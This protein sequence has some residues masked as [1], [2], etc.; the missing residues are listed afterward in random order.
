MASLSR[1]TFLQKSGV[2]A[3]ALTIVPSY[4]VSGV[5]RKKKVKAPSDKLNIAGIGIGGMGHANL[6]QMA[7]ENIVA[8]CDAD[9]AYAKPIFNLYS[10]AKRYWDYRKMFDEMGK[11]IDAVLVATPDHLHAI[12]AAEAI[13]L[14]KHVYC[15]KPL[16]HSIYESRL[17]TKLAAKYKVCTQMGNQG[18]SG[19]GVNNICEWIW[20]G[21][22][23][24][25][26]RVDAATDRP[27]WPAG[28]NTP[29]NEEKVPDTFNWDL[30]TGPAKMRPYHGVYH[31]F[32]W[33]GW[34][35]YGTGSLGDMG[36]HILHPVFAALNL[37]Y[38]TMVEASSSS[39]LRD[40]TPSAEIIKYTFPAR[41]NLPKVAMPEVEVN[42]Y[43]GG[44]LPD[45][46][47]GFPEKKDLMLDGGG[48]TIF[49]GT[50]D[51]LVCA[52]YGESPFLLSGRVPSA[53][54]TLPRTKLSHEQDW[55]RACKE[56]PENRVL[57]KSDFSVAG[58][59]NEMIVMGAM[60]V[61]LQ[62]LH[63]T[64]LWDGENMKFTNIDD[65]DTLSFKITDSVN[66]AYGSVNMTE[67]VSAKAFAEE[68]VRHNYR[69]GWK[70]PEL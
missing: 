31:P 18:A 50:K 20:N 6:E 35:D 2:A 33:R 53:P 51:T 41:E 34:W 66:T 38:P 26:V 48:V 5:N 39:L 57:P 68:L 24:D 13:T 52:C 46:P 63:R 10:N 55:I 62:G 32:R 3:A 7:A 25:V 64:L 11:S 19:E 56:S 59:F 44:L 29:T 70:L 15:Q 60:A 4:A 43:D 47:K 12:I 1:R 67:P 58:P 61:R 40:C 54:K 16:T 23:G 36:C 27:W 28:I 37:R 21:E 65:K 9:W 69:E 17:L 42:W 8:L 22:I 14:G 30:F 49:H 45:R